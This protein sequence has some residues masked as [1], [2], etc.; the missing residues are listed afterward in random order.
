MQRLLSISKSSSVRHSKSRSSSE[1]SS[2]VGLTANSRHSAKYCKRLIL[3]PKVDDEP[4]DGP[5]SAEPSEGMF[6]GRHVAND[7]REQHGRRESIYGA[8]QELGRSYFVG[9][10]LA[11]A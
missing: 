7:E 4:S 11:G 1:H 8:W 6:E 5:L 2:L 10:S 9:R 3:R